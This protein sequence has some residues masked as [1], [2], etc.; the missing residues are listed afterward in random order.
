MQKFIILLI[1]GYSYAIGP[2]FGPSCRFWP[3]CSNYAIDAIENHGVI[4]GAWLL[5]MRLSRC[6]PWHPGGVDPV[7]KAESESV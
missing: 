5:T 4:R 1:R 6:H 3:T 7:P 2:F